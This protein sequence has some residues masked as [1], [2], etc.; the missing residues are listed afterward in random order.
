MWLILVPLRFFVG[1]GLE[2]TR[3][4]PLII[5]HLKKKY[6]CKS[7]AEV[8]EAWIPGDL[9]YATRI[10][11]DMLIVTIVLCYSVIA[12][13]ILPFGVAYFGIG[14]VVLRNQVIFI[15]CVS[16][17]LEWYHRNL[18]INKQKTY[19]FQRT[20][21]QGL[22]PFIREQWEDVA[23]HVHPHHG[24]VDP[25]SSNNVGLLYREEIHLHST[26]DPSSYF[27]LHLSYRLQQKIL[28]ILPINSTGCG[29]PRIERSPEYGSCVQVI[30]SAKLVF[31]ERWWWGSV[32][33]CFVSSF[34]NRVRGLMLYM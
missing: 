13:L 3:I 12:P 5:F 27:L 6:L 18:S 22:C 31:W 30:R 26:A 34:K 14:W 2:L 15:I 9:G 19:I 10:P 1:Y 21:T 25:L 11:G 28:S 33:G 23:S 16:S 20:G 7:E 24:F 29:L 32:W 17:I 8:K 4:V